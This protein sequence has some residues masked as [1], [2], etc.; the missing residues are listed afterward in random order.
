MIRLRIT[1]DGRIRGLWTDDIGFTEFGECVA[2]RASHVEFDR[3]R[4]C[5]TVREAVPRGRFRRWIQRLLPHAT[6][7]VVYRS[8][9]RSAALEW[10]QRHFQPG[11]L[12]WSE[13]G[14]L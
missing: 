13:R 12:G 14:L 1:P 10:E 11:S 8:A 9:T 7:R 3:R 6:G 5:W 2:R 4:Q